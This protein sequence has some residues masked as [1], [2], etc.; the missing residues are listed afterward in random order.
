VLATLSQGLTDEVLGELQMATK[1]NISAKPTTASKPARRESIATK[2]KKFDDKMAKLRNVFQWGLSD[3]QTDL[4]R[5]CYGDLSGQMANAI[6]TAMA[7]LKES[8]MYELMVK[9]FQ[10]LGGDFQLLH[11]CGRIY[12]AGKMSAKRFKPELLSQE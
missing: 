12:L 10:Q 1:K 4:S 11:L 7:S 8:P 9:D 6:T 2:I 3:A 5:T